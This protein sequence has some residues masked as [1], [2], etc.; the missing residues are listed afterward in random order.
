MEEIWKIVANTE[1]RYEVSSMGRIKSLPFTIEVKGKSSFVTRERILR[2]GTDRDG[3]DV[4]VCSINSK[5]YTKRGHRVVAETFIPNPNNLPQVNHKNSIRNDNRVENL[6]WVSERD[7]MMHGIEY[8]NVKP[9]KGEI[10][11]MSK[12]TKD[13]VIEIRA[14]YETGRSYAEIAKDYDV[15]GGAIGKIIRRE[16][17]KHIK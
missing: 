15:G 8:G 13:K 9:T 3:Y 17:W 6:E 1:G 5:R 4:F 12:L 14:A 7:N 11:G 10:N 2:L 16:R